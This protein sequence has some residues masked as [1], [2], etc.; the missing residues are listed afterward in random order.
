MTADA[1][2]ANE[3]FAIN[4]AN[5]MIGLQKAN[6]CENDATSSC[7][8]DI[9]E[10]VLSQSSDNNDDNTNDMFEQNWR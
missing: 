10:E 2:T 7:E 6:V 5:K 4:D 8:E 9:Q 1:I 3:S